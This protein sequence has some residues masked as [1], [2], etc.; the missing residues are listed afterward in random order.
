[1]ANLDKVKITLFHLSSSG[2]NNYYLY[3][4]ASDELRAKY[5]I[6][7][8]T[9]E[10]FRYNRY[11]DFSD[12]Y[13]TTH[14]EYVSHYD[15]VNIDLWHGFPLKGMA[16]M[17]KQESATDEHIQQHWSKMDM[18][19]SYSTLY[20]TA[21]NACNGANIR[22]YRVTG[23]PRNDA[24]LSRE[25]KDRLQ[26]LLPQLDIRNESVVFFMPTFRK[27]IITP[28]KMEG[29]K[30]FNNIFGLLKFEREKLLTF[31]EHNQISLV[32]KLHPFEESFFADELK[33][34]KSSRIFI[35]ND[36]M[37]SHASMDLYDVLGAA[38]MLITDYSSVY[39]DY[40]LLDRP[41]LFLPT[42][43]EAY[44]GNRGL[45][46]EPYDFWTP[47]PKV[48]TQEEMQDAIHQF[49]LGQDVYAE[50]RRTILHLCHSFHDNKSSERIWRLID[51]YIQEQ[52][53]VILERRETLQTHKKM[54]QQI[55][56]KINEMI[57]QGHLAQANE[58]LNQYLETNA[59]DPDIFAMNG[60]LHL[61]T[62]NPREAI[63]TFERGHQFFP[64]DEDLLYN[65]GYVHE[66]LEEYEAALQYYAQAKQQT[67]KSQ[68]LALLDEKI[69]ALSAEK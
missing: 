22:Q 9:E 1:M 57:E 59:A 33:A 52:M 46:F 50:Q 26:E 14:G 65:L 69:A 39:I 64:W 10:Q 40:L 53:D 32:V 2:S 42:D 68:L 37:L 58:A 8:L 15:K 67:S 55:K 41:I 13:I 62:N 18:I 20:N 54:Q 51:D 60:M 11:I 31:L 3:H 49:L 36:A 56:Q 4:S 23:V 7:L 43:L 45:L 29:S 6:E 5:D 24:L 48:Y 35:L 12:V 19:M 25:S 21:M 34:L 61:L 38:D 47:G 66:S 17:D 27:S 28:N 63:Q 30:N 16:K 44:K